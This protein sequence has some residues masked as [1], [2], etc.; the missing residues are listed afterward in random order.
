[1]IHVDF[2]NLHTFSFPAQAQEL[3]ANALSFLIS[4]WEGHLTPPEAANLADK[5]SKSRDAAMVRAGEAK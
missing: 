1:M 3:G 5:A 4:T 2:G